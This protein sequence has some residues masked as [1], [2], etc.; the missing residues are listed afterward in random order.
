MSTKV[1]ELFYRLAS[2]LFCLVLIFMLVKCGDN[3]YNR[4]T[5]G[6][7]KALAD[8]RGSFSTRPQPSEESLAEHCQ[9]VSRLL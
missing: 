1:F 8:M 7:K 6:Y 3:K 5:E 4:L 2:L 9:L